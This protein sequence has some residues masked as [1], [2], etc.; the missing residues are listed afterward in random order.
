M[1]IMPPVCPGTW[2]LECHHE[3]VK[4][5]DIADARGSLDA[6]LADVAAGETVTIVHDGHA[7]AVLTP[8]DEAAALDGLLERM[9]AAHGPVDEDEVAAIFAPLTEG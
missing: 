6:L 7:V 8:P 3:D 9:E 2:T 5:V 4:T 1:L